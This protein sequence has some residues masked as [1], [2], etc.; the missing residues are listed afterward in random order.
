MFV[1]RVAQ[2]IDSGVVSNSVMVNINADDFEIFVGSVLTNP[3]TVQNSQS[4]VFLSDSFF[5]DR[6][7]R[8]SEFLLV[9]SDTVGFSVDYTLGHG[10]LSSSSSDSDSIK[11]LDVLF[12]MVPVNNISLFGFVSQFS[13]FIGS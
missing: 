11:M 12:V 7:Q 10:S 8:S 5:G 9:N 1:R 3:I 6:S 13:G 4:S 2:P